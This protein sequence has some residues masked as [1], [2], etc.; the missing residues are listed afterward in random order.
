MLQHLGVTVGYNRWPMY[1]E[2]RNYSRTMHDVEYGCF[3]VRIDGARLSR[4]YANQD[5]LSNLQAYSKQDQYLVDL[6]SPGA[7][8]LQP[9]IWYERRRPN[10]LACLLYL[11]HQDPIDVNT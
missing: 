8:G 5:E 10:P 6:D 4:V 11:R 9:Q 2:A 7:R 1:M 3:I